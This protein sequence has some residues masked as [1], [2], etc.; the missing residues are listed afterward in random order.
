MLALMYYQCQQQQQQQQQELGLM[1]QP[2]HQT[3]KSV[4]PSFP[5]M[6]RETQQTATQHTNTYGKTTFS[7]KSTQRVQSADFGQ[8]KCSPDLKCVPRVEIQTPDADEFQHL[9]ETS[10]PQIHQ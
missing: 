5:T 6:T 4:C 8:S 7:I 9:T 3:V 10:C 1:I 2:L